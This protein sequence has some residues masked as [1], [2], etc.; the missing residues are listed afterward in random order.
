MSG[1]TSSG[2]ND[3]YGH[4]AGIPCVGQLD[5]L[6]GYM[7]NNE[8]VWPKA[9]LWDTKIYKRHTAVIF[10]DGNV[11]QASQKTSTDPNA[12]PWT[13]L[14]IPWTAGTYH[15]GDTRL[16]SG[17][18]WT[19]VAT[20]SV[21][22][23]TSIPPE[24]NNR[25]ETQDQTPVNGW[26]Y[27]CTPQTWVSGSGSNFWA[28]NSL[29]AWKGRLY[30]TPTGT[31]AE[32]PNSPW[33]LWKVDRASSPN[34]LKITV[35]DRGE[36]FQYWGTPDQTLDTVDEA[37]LAALG[38][39]DYKDLP[40]TM[41]KS[42]LFG[43]SQTNPPD[44]VVLGGRKPVQTLITG[45][46]TDFD[47]DW[48]I[49]PW[50]YI[51]EKLTHPKFGLGLKNSIFNQT[52]WQ[53]E[54]DRCAANPELYYISPMLTSLTNVRNLVADLLGYPDGIIFWTVIGLLSAGHWPHNEAAPAFTA[55][56]TIDINDVLREIAPTSN[57]WDD[58]SSS[59]V[60]S[61]QDIQGGFKDRPAI[62]P[63]LFNMAITQRIKSEQFDRP[64]ITRF[65]QASAW[66]SERAKIAGDQKSGGSIPVRA[67]KAST[68]EPGS[69]FLLTNDE[70]SL[71]EPQRCTKKV[72]SLSKGEITLS[73]E[74]ERGL[75]PQ[76]FSPTAPNPSEAQG[77]LPATV[78]NFA[79]VQ[80]PSALAG[81]ANTLAVITGREND[82]TSSMEIW[83]KQADAISFQKLGTNRGFAVVGTLATDAND[84]IFTGTPGADNTTFVTV[85]AV[86][87]GNTYDLGNTN[88]WRAQVFYSV[89]SSGIPHSTGTEGIDYILDP[90]T[91]TL[92]IVTGGNIPTGY[93]V[94]VKLWQTLAIYYNA[95]TPQTDLDAISSV[96]TQDEIDDGQILLFA[97]RADNPA[98]FEIMSVRSVTSEGMDTAVNKPVIFVNVL[99]TQFGTLYGGDGSYVWGTNP[100]D[101]IMIIKKSSLTPLSHENFPFYHDHGT[102]INLRLAPASAWV[103]AD[104]DDLY[105]P[106]SNPEG[107]ST[108]FDYSFNDLYAPTVSLLQIV[109]N[110]GQIAGWGV[111]S[112]IT[113]DS[114]QILLNVQARNNNLAHITI[115]GLRGDEQTTLYSSNLKPQSSQNVL[116]Q[117]K[118][119]RPGG[120][121]LR[122]NALDLAGNNVAFLTPD[123]GTIILVGG[124]P[125]TSVSPCLETWAVVGSQVT[126]LKFGI[127]SYNSLTLFWQVKPRGT[128]PNAQGAGGG[129]W[130][131]I[132]SWNALAS[133]YDSAAIPNF[134][135]G[136][137]L[138]AYTTT[139]GQAN[140]D[141]IQFNIDQ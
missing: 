60:V 76:P 82:F 122:I 62:A 48:N 71:S 77:P 68:I 134:A 10:T 135:A 98:L 1:K 131:S 115:T 5:F 140:S 16:Y 3:F 116:I 110:G 56:N 6:W 28:A 125:T 47:A 34:P 46:A 7:V 136:Q 32:P 35:E 94:N 117:L 132:S 25:L 55:A 138:Y 33:V 49:N 119:P 51:A 114:I 27:V 121:R 43:T 42:F 22:P 40:V 31:K 13:L 12:F 101:V 96:P 139:S 95:N 64:F 88:F 107:L 83:F 112:F 109:R 75:S 85:G 69:I 37:I 59:A 127:F 70:F 23:P 118:F 61:F 79:A 99:R 41:L 90:S 93:Y 65:A 86:T 124:T 30:T 52:A 106:A 57:G 4:I 73:H 108:A 80:L 15:V 111:V 11:Y 133:G 141:T 72:T 120:W 54:A 45:A 129:V 50:C 21:A 20:T 97:V 18:V 126:G 63:N 67:E 2:S 102:T 19:A 92:K 91:G 24:E 128:A 58:T 87:Q 74:T 104:I 89:N 8:L 123:D 78:R 29:V 39:P 105:D 9:K 81:E 137:T 53:S 100:N 130:H 44:V 84:E 66:A 103:Q 14:A 113:T 38:H 36:I 17:F 26:V